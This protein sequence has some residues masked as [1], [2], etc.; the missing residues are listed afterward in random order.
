MKMI[1]VLAMIG[2]SASPAAASTKPVDL[3]CSVKSGEKVS[4]IDLSLNEAARTATWQ[5]ED[6]P[7]PI[8]GPAV[9]SSTKVVIGT[10]TID[11][12]NLS[13]EQRYNDG[14]KLV[15]KTGTCKLV[16]VPRAF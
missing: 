8:S 2:A 14:E 9:F 16:K 5:W 3:N 6:Y 1:L 7:E 10:I 15:I 11:R 12:T 13:I 4:T